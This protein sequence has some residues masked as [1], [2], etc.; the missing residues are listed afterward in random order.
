V[1]EACDPPLVRAG[2]FAL[3]ALREDLGPT[4]LAAAEGRRGG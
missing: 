4:A 2:D 1:T 3:Y